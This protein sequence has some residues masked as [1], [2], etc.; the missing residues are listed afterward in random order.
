MED[1]NPQSE[2]YKLADHVGKD[3]EKIN[4]DLISN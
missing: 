2:S 1:K 3:S 4:S